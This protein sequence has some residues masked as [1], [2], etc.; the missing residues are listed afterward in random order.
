MAESELAMSINIVPIFGW[1]FSYR[2]PPP[3]SFRKH[4][5]AFVTFSFQYVGFTLAKRSLSVEIEVDPPKIE[6]EIFEQDIADDT[7]SI[8]TNV[9]F[10]NSALFIEEV[11][12]EIASRGFP[13]RI[14]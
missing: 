11:I 10:D 8:S 4:T 14:G 6:E 2:R 13:I 9:V 12:F 7:L 5:L 1:V 3:V